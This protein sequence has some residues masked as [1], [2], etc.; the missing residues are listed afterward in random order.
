MYSIGGI[1]WHPNGNVSHFLQITKL[2]YDG[3]LITDEQ[4]ISDAMN[5]HFCDARRNLQS[6]LENCTLNFKDYRR[7]T[8]S[9]YL[10]PINK[11]DILLAIKNLK[12]TKRPVAIW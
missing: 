8:N 5:M 7:K 2:I 11:E 12:Q 1:Y 3:K 4:N 9:F 6:Q 10:T